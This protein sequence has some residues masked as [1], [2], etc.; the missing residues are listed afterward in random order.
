[1][2]RLG[3]LSAWSEPLSLGLAVALLAALSAATGMLIYQERQSWAILRDLRGALSKI[4][5]S[6]AALVQITPLQQH[7][8]PRE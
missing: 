8:R 1:V 7:F 5:P 4:A 3:S 2:V 6:Y